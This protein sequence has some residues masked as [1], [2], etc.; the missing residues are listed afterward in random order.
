MLGVWF[1]KKFDLYKNK[2]FYTRLGVHSY[3]SVKIKNVLKT[4]NFL[5]SAQYVRGGGYL[6]KKIRQNLG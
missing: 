3:G 2:M 1:I 6:E 4:L 5:I